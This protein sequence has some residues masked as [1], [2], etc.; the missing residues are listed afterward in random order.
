[1]DAYV[2]WENIPSRNISN[3]KEMVGVVIGLDEANA[4]LT[5][6]KGQEDAGPNLESRIRY[7]KEPVAVLDTRN[8][9]A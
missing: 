9:L 7:W 8:C 6:L 5:K 1:M 4:V 2:I 3:L